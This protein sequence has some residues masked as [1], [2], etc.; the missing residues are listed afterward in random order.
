MGSSRNGRLHLIYGQDP[1]LEE[2]EA[3][4]PWTVQ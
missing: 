2:G 1:G 4:P 3:F